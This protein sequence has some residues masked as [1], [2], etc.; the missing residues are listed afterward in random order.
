MSTN[1]D[2]TA[3]V[4]AGAHADAALLLHGMMCVA[5]ADGSFA[6]AEMRMVEGYFAQLPELRGRDFDALMDEAHAIVERHGTVAESLSELSRLSSRALKTK[7]YVVAA[8]IAL[9]TEQVDAR[10]GA[11][12]ASLQSVL[13]IDDAT[14]T[15]ILEVLAL[16]YA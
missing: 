1:L 2:R 6:E 12:L 7:L 16:K 15:A 5:G 8:D 4:Q 3:N 11:M 13:E 14:A 10:E 9:A